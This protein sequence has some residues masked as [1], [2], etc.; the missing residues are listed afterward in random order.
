MVK[1]RILVTNDD[2]VDARGIKTLTEVALEFGE[3][4]V[5]APERGMSGMSHSITMSHPLFVRKIEERE[6]LTIYG[7][8][9]TPVDCVKVA[10]DA[11]LKE[12]PP[13]LVLS[14]INHGANTNLSV[15]YSGTM[16]AAIE[17]STYKIPSIGVS[18]MSHDTSYDLEAAKHYAREIIRMVVE[19]YPTQDEIYNPQFTPICLNVNVP[20]LPLCEIKGIRFCRQTRGYWK[21]DFEQLFDPRGREYYWLVGS[22]INEEYDA[23]DTDEWAIRN[24]YVAAVPVQTDLTN[25]NLLQSSKNWK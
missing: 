1:H 6:N 14:G 18:Q 9:G 13:T 19:N 24:G 16:G 7:C 17:G 21:E 15:L 23:E 20:N 4:V 11:I 2:G 22:F 8:D 12:N 10:F 3:V 25:Y 5:V